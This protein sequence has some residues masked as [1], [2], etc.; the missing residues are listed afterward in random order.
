M[1]SSTRAHIRLSI[2]KVHGFRIRT[3]HVPENVHTGHDTDKQDLAKQAHSANFASVI[4]CSKTY[5][6]SQSHTPSDEPKH[7]DQA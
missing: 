5:E 7:N 3:N 1:V 6:V 2:V 4:R